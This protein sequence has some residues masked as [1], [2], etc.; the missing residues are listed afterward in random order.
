MTNDRNHLLSLI[1]EHF[2]MSLNVNEHED[3]EETFTDEKLTEYS[4]LNIDPIFEFPHIYIVEP[5]QFTSEERQKYETFN[6]IRFLYMNDSNKKYSCYVTLYFYSTIHL[7]LLSGTNKYV[8]SAQFIDLYRKYFLS[9]DLVHRF[10]DQCS[11]DKV[12]NEQLGMN[13]PSIYITSEDPKLPLSMNHVA[14][15]KRIH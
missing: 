13:G 3:N 6:Q 12:Y 9:S 1:L 2:M 5:E 8:I 14:S 11:I 7:L 15:L 4:N 10:K